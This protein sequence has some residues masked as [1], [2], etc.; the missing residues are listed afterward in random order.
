MVQNSEFC[1]GPRVISPA[2]QGNPR[3]PVYQ[4][5]RIYDHLEHGFCH[6]CDRLSAIR[7]RLSAT[8]ISFTIWLTAKTY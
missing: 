3:R 8:A 4:K 6:Q 5:S 1:H 2:K 7:Y